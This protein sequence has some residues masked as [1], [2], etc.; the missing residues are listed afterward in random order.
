MNLVKMNEEK[1]K[2]I[3]STFHREQHFFLLNIINGLRVTSY[4]YR[5]TSYG[6]Q[7]T[8]HKIGVNPLSTRNPQRTTRNFFIR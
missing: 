8:R 3:L 4:A 6:P 5:V 1:E 7:V 2:N